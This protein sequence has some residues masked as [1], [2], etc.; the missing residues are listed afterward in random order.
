M[1]KNAHIANKR[2][3]NPEIGLE[4][5]LGQEDKPLFKISGLFSSKSGFCRLKRN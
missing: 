1:I 4:R 3:R 5:F 2:I